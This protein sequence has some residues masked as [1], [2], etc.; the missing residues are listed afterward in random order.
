VSSLVL[1]VNTLSINLV[2][3][4]SHTTILSPGANNI[5]RSNSN[6]K[7]MVGV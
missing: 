2:F 1:F 3:E 4:E 5:S 7:R 6:G